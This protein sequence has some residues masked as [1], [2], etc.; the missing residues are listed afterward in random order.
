MNFH[1][2]MDVG[3]MAGAVVRALTS[4]QYGPGSIP[5]HGAISGLSSLVLFSAPLSVKTNISFDVI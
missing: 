1:S 4:H 5:R 3:S 2:L